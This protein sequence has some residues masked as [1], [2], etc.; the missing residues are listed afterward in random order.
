MNCGWCLH[1]EICVNIVLHNSLSNIISTAQNNCA[2]TDF[3]DIFCD[4][5]YTP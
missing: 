2:F 3:P 4:M 5:W 1:W